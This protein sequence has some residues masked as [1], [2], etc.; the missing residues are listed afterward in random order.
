MKADSFRGNGEEF[1]ETEAVE[2]PFLISGLLNRIFS[3]EH[4]T[5]WLNF[6]PSS[7]IVHL[8]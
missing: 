1:N 6:I 2:P 3:T 7:S 5:G 8:S 4:S